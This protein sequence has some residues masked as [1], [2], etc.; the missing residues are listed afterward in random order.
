M[1]ELLIEP[2]NSHRHDLKEILNEAEAL[3]RERFGARISSSLLKKWN[4]MIED[5]TGLALLQ[6]S[7]CAGLLLYSTEYELG[8]SSLLSP[9]SAHR[10]PQSATISA[11]FVLRRARENSIKGERRLVKSAIA[12]LK[13]DKSIETIAVQ[14]PPL[15]DMNLEGPLARM[16]FM[17]CKRVRMGRKL[18][19]RIA[20]GSAPPGCRAEA[21]TEQDAD[22]LR[23]A[24]YHGYFAEIDGYLFPDI[25]AVCSDGALFRE[26]LSSESVDLGASVMARVRGLPAGGVIA[27]SDK[28]RRVGLIGV[29]VVVPNMRRRGIGRFMLLD[30]LRRLKAQHHERAALAVTVENR[31]AHTLYSSLGFEEIGPHKA[32]SV[33]RRSVSRPLMNY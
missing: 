5:G 26:F 18:S 1:F 20:Y 32:V 6:G 10:L 4:P 31:P 33:W 11:C 22:E 7:D 23:A 19:D 16:G 28:G 15:Y 27:L 14:I 25:A 3:S 17:N 29:V 9:S 21:P 24:I 8:F 12:R 2:I 30:V 13:S